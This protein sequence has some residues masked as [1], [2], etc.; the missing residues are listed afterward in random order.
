MMSISGLVCRQQ[1][2]RLAKLLFHFGLPGSA[3]EKINLGTA[4]KFRNPAGFYGLAG[5]N[6][7]TN[8]ITQRP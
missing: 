3:R 4:A 6:Q 2:S 8:K 1:P 5:F 7:S